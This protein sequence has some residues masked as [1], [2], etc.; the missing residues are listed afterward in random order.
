MAE[1]KKA[2]KKKANRKPHRS[3]AQIARDKRRISDLY[4]E[5]MLQAEIAEILGIAQSTV[6]RDIRSLQAEWLKDAQSNFEEMKAREIAKVERLE[7]E[8]YKGWRR[9]FGPD[10]LVGDKSVAEDDEPELPSGDPRFL[11]GVGKCIQQRC[12]IQ[13]VEAP[14]E[15]DVGPRLGTILGA[16]PDSFKAG[17]L[18]VLS[19]EGEKK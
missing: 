2:K 12:K 17:V 16:L 1:K 15:H 10:D 8:Y 4:L 19:S 6:S 11:A 3:P 13:G 5:G 14:T 9:S 18:E 7:R